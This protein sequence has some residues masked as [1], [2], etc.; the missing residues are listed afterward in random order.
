MKANVEPGKTPE[1]QA[2][3]WAIEYFQKRAEALGQ[4]G[5]ASLVSLA[6]DAADAL[7]DPKLVPPG[8]FDECLKEL[9]RSA[10]ADGD[11]TAG[12][13]LS[14][15]VIKFIALGKP[16]PE[17]LRYFT[18]FRLLHPGMTWCYDPDLDEWSGQPQKRKPGPKSGDWLVRDVTVVHAIHH[19][20]LTWKFQPTRNPA[21]E[22]P[23]A[24]SIVRDAMA[25]VGSKVTEAAVNKIWNENGR[26]FAEASK[27]FP[28]IYKTVFPVA[29]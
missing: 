24:A 16:F 9:V 10:L 27:L 20:V 19:I 13:Y 12:I 21:T 5:S 4:R 8:Q 7:M 23:S 11:E 14:G 28:E 25:A 2:L 29:V 26:V 3:G 1:K 17:P 22:G 18:M 6:Y 15:V